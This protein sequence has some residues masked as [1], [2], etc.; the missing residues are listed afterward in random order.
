MPRSHLA[1]PALTHST[2]KRSQGG[3]PK[4]GGIHLSHPVFIP[5]LTKLLLRT[6]QAK[7][8]TRPQGVETG[9]SGGHALLRQ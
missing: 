4:E 8:H 5:Q 7:P 3:L 1:Q 9:F 2:G 6:P